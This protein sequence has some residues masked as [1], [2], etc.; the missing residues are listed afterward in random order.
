MYVCMDGWMHVLM[1]VC[2][3]TRMH[4]RTHAHTCTHARM[5]GRTHARTHTYM[6]AC[7]HASSHACVLSQKAIDTLLS[8]AALGNCQTRKTSAR[9]EPASNR[10]MSQQAIGTQPASHQH[11]QSHRAVSTCNAS[12]PSAHDV[13]ASHQ[14]MSCQPAISTCAN[15]QLARACTDCSS[16]MPSRASNQRLSDLASRRWKSA[17]TSASAGAQVGQGAYV[18]VQAKRENLTCMTCCVRGCY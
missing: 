1:H 2:M 12:Q 6:H 5:S 18:E 11:M 13:P 16:H 17:N 3:C 8:Q 10:R 7:M 15:A 4:T 14:H 9:A